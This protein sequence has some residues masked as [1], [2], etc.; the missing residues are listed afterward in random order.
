[1]LVSLLLYSYAIG[2][3]SSRKIEQKTYEDIAFRIISGNQHPDHDTISD[4]R[5]DNLKAFSSLFLKVLE[6]AKKLNLVSLGHVALDGTK[7]KANA[8]KHKAMTYVRMI[9]KEI[10][11]Q[12]KIS[13]LLKEA[14]SVDKK[15]D[16]IY[17]KGK[18]LLTLPEE[19]KYHKDRLEKIRYYNPCQ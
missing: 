17:G 6:L 16:K 8:S 4:F 14:E 2:L 9:K 1:M 12:D 11:L 5:K 10:E 7:I 3:P 13:F 15:E 18:N 19:L